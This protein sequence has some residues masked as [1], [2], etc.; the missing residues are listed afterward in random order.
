MK[1]HCK[2]HRIKVNDRE[3]QVGSKLLDETEA[4]SPCPPPTPHNLIM[5]HTSENP[6]QLSSQGHIGLNSIQN[7]CGHQKQEKSKSHSLLA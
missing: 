3:N 1:K 6:G 2:Q 5:R 4:A 7:A